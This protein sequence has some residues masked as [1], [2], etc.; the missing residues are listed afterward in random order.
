MTFI[1]RIF[2]T[3]LIAF[4]PNED[5]TQLTVLLLNMPHEYRVSD[6]TAIP[7]HMP[8]LLARAGGCAGQCP[9]RDADIAHFL[10]AGEALPDAVDALQNALL[11]G[12]GWALA[13]SELSIR[14]GC[15]AES[16]LGSPLAIQ[17]NLR[18]SENGHPSSIPLSAEERSDFS[19][20]ADVRQLNAAHRGFSPAVLAAEPPADLVAAR[21]T[22]RNGRI[23]TYR[24]VQIDG[25]V[26]PVHFQ[27]LAGG[28]ELP[29]AQAVAS[30]VVAEIEVSGDSV[31]V[32]DQPFGAAK[33]R[34]TMTLAPQN[35]VVE[36]AVLNLPPFEAPVV[37]MRSRPGAGRHFERFF[38]LMSMPVPAAARPVPQALTRAGEPAIDW[39][40]VHPQAEQWSD[41][42]VKLRMGITR[43]PYDQTLCPLGQ[44]GVP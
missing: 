22:L 16:G 26:E 15:P 17:T 6:G 7:H 30:W 28:A 13:G 41:L 40:V 37:Q 8:L 27:P 42:L 4:V 24:L 35:G 12:G 19:W 3:G 5:R 32:A 25:K 36:V 44:G 2:F 31:Q 43:G 14:N 1:L 10:F 9:Q 33:A 34:R 39:A 23:S 21:L 11:R 29:Y 20:V 18:R 38:D